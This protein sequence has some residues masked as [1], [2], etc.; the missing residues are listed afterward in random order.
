[1]P[2]RKYNLIIMIIKIVII[3]KIILNLTI[4]TNGIYQT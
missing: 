1:M 2:D 4:R 3:I